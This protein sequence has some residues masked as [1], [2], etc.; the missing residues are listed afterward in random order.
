MSATTAAT[1]TAMVAS[2]IVM[3]TWNR[4]SG[5]D[6]STGHAVGIA[7]GGSHDT[8]S[9]AVRRYSSS[10]G[11]IASRLKKT[12]G[13]RLDGIAQISDAPATSRPYH[14]GCDRMTDSESRCS[15]EYLSITHS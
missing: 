9:N 7:T 10:A 4:W 8:S 3:L 1:D 12:N 13:V 2:T 5:A 15:A 11:P 6:T 14:V